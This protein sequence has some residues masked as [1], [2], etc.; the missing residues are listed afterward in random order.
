[1]GSN[2]QTKYIH[3]DTKKCK[4]CWQCIESCKNKVIDKVNIF[5]HKHAKIK[6]AESCVGCYKCVE[7]CENLAISKIGPP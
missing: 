6:N 7:I 2:H 5:F 4:A 1:M 3:I